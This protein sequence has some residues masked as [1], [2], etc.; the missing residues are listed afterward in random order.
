MPDSSITTSSVL[1]FNTNNDSPELRGK[2]ID[3]NKEMTI[4]TGSN[5]IG[6]NEDKGDGERIPSISIKERK[7]VSRP[8]IAQ[9]TDISDIPF[10]SVFG[11]SGIQITDVNTF[12]SILKNEAIT[13]KSYLRPTKEK[14]LREQGLDSKYPYKNN[15][16]NKVVCHRIQT[17]LDKA[18]DFL[19]QTDFKNS[20]KAKRAINDA[21]NELWFKNR[22][23]SIDDHNIGTYFSIKENSFAR[24]FH[25][26]AS[27]LPDSDPK[28]KYYLRIADYIFSHKVSALGKVN[29]KN[30]EHD[31]ELMLTDPKTR[32]I[33][34]MEKG[35]DS[36]IKYLLYKLPDDYNSEKAGQYIYRDKNTYYYNNT[37]KKVNKKKIHK[38]ENFYLEEVVLNPKPEHAKLRRGMEFDWNDNGILDHGTKDAHWWGA[39]N[40][41]GLFES[42]GLIFPFL[43]NI[44]IFN[45]ETKKDVTLQQRHILD[46]VAGFFDCGASYEKLHDAEKVVHIPGYT[47][48]GGRYN[49]AF[50]KISFKF[51]DSEGKDKELP[52]SVELRSIAPQNNAPAS[53]DL[54][55]VFQNKVRPDTTSIV[56][57]D[58]KEIFKTEKRDRHYLKLGKNDKRIITGQFYGETFDENGKYIEKILQNFSIDPNSKKKVCIGCYKDEKNTLGEKTLI[59]TYYNP[60]TQELTRGYTEVTKNQHGKYEIAASENDQKV[61]ILGFNESLQIRY[62]VSWGDDTMGR[63]KFLDTFMKTGSPL[64]ADGEN[65]TAEVW[66]GKLEYCK[67]DLKRE[68]RN[69]ENGKEFTYR[70]YEYTLRTTFRTEKRGVIICKYDEAG[71]LI[72]ACEE[73]GVIKN[74]FNDNVKK[75]QQ[76]YDK[77]E[78][79]FDFIWKDRRKFAP[80]TVINEK[81]YLN[82]TMVK[83]KYLTHN[84]YQTCVDAWQH[85]IEIVYAASKLEKKDGAGLMYYQNNLYYYENESDRLADIRTLMQNSGESNTDD[86]YYGNT[87]NTTRRRYQKTNFLDSLIRTLFSCSICHA[88]D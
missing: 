76:V 79:L 85:L 50:S 72:D 13:Y 34:S 6:L 66:N 33:V 21:A 47:T 77:D 40:L 80:Y 11:Q 5:I 55:L 16:Y 86:Y 7:V 75:W 22:K 64:V 56:F 1:P 53:T 68:K 23:V 49:E 27:S 17:Y 67:K 84:N 36:E 54:N 69:I 31:T 39:C 61:K 37:G 52:C 71:E 48:A 8:E 14:V 2:K 41:K 12:I 43:E 44:H 26:L 82:K 4:V 81:P 32:A 20:V 9:E 45:T 28:K 70:E 65:K 24:G 57:E 51:K 19:A 38:L 10:P 59:R 25:K 18:K 74:V 78:S 15:L 58:K 3:K 88:G 83:R 87:E 62:E 73:R 29:E 42:L 35:S 30:I 60:A 63:V 46:M